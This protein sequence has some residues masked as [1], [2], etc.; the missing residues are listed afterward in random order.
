MTTHKTPHHM[1][2]KISHKITAIKDDITGAVKE[3]SR[4]ISFDRHLSSVANA[5]SSCQDESTPTPKRMTH[6][7]KT[8]GMY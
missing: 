2:D 8:S 5:D 3:R 4:S 1:L 7:L 6:L